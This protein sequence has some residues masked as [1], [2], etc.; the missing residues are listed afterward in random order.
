MPGSGLRVGAGRRSRG[1]EMTRVAA[2]PSAL[3]R[4]SDVAIVIVD[5]HPLLREGLKHILS[6]EGFRVIATA[7]A[8]PALDIAG[9]MTDG[10]VL[11]LIGSDEDPLATVGQVLAIRKD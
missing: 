3:P 2:G 10:T 7:S 8:L 11:F 5:A 1:S 9:R 6:G 4:R